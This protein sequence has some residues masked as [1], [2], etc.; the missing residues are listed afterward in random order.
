[1]TDW[2]KYEARFNACKSR[3]ESITTEIASAFPKS[4]VFESNGADYR[5]RAIIVREDG[6]EFGL[7]FEI[8]DSG[9]ADDGIYG[10]HGNFNLSVCADGGLVVGSFVPFNYTDQCWVDYSDT[11]EWDKRLGMME[12]TASEVIDAINEFSAE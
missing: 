6:E 3:M 8:W 12:N 5:F 2:T 7:D 4:E 9:E 1:M 10:K 11:K